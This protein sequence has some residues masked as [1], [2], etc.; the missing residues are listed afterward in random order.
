MQIACQIELYDRFVDVK[1]SNEFQRVI[2]YLKGVDR[3]GA[4]FWGVI[5][6]GLGLSGLRFLRRETSWSRRGSF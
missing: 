1:K 3:K 5:S 6:S 2:F 4:Q